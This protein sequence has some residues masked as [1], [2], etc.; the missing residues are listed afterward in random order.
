MHCYDPFWLRSNSRNCTLILIRQI[1]LKIICKKVGYTITK[2]FWGKNDS[3]LSSFFLH[4]YLILSN[5]IVFLLSQ[6]CNFPKQALQIVVDISFVN[7]NPKARLNSRPGQL[8]ILSIFVVGITFLSIKET[9]QECK[10]NF[11][12]TTI[13]AGTI[14]FIIS[15]H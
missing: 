7:S 15:I 9:N 12:N 11:S 3:L 13:N 5:K 6:I 1:R 10:K 4:F 14:Y 2:L 8:P